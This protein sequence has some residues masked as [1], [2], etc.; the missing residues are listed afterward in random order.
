MVS[1]TV[2]GVNI[3]LGFVSLLVGVVNSVV[4]MSVFILFA[5]QIYSFIQII[6]F[7]SSIELFIPPGKVCVCIKCVYVSMKSVCVCV[8][9]LVM[10]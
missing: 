5:I 8:Y 2:D 6:S 3:V 1:S 4:C 7:F 9:V 10:W